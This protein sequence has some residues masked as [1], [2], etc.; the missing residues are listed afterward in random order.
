M[1]KRMRKGKAELSEVEI[2]H[3]YEDNNLSRKVDVYN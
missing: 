3:M 2:W 1:K